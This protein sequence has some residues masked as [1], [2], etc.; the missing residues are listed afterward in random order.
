[1][2]PTHF[3]VAIRYDEKT[4]RAPQVIS[5]GA[6]LLAMKIRDIAKTNAIPVLQSP[7]LARALYAN[8]ELDREIPASLF[9]AVAQVLA[10][11]YKLKAALRGDGPMPEELQQPF[12]PPELDPFSKVVAH[13]A[14]A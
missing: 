5:K 3:A 8:A 14:R 1:M 7:M 10:Y 12:V 13:T 11:I 6:D 9:T 4:M 2:N